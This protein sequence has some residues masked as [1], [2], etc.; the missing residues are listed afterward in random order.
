MVAPVVA[1]LGKALLSAATSAVAKRAI[2]KGV[3]S[4]FENAFS[5]KDKDGIRS[6]YTDGKDGSWSKRPSNPTAYTI[7]RDLGSTTRRFGEIVFEKSAELSRSEGIQKLINSGNAF[8]DRITDTQ[9]IKSFEGLEHKA[10]TAMAH[11]INAEISHPGTDGFKTT[12]ANLN[13]SMGSLSFTLDNF[14]SKI[15]DKQ[16]SQYKAIEASLRAPL[17]INAIDQIQ[18]KEMV[19]QAKELAARMRQ[20]N[21]HQFVGIKPGANAASNKEVAQVQ[22]ERMHG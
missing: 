8:I 4:A 21:A 12:I 2:A 15:E 19:A 1:I 5:D 7:G 9:A 3:A 20:G 17:S 22:Y 6:Q 14:K 13:S 10:I 16:F 18:N 11:R